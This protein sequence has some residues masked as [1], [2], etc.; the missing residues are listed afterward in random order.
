MSTRPVFPTALPGPTG[1]LPR[2]WHRV[3]WTVNAG[4][5]HIVTDNIAS[6]VL[7]L[8]ALKAHAESHPE[9]YQDV[10]LQSWSDFPPQER[11]ECQS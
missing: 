6:A 5:Q 3:T 11:P 8:V 2:G 9:E 1:P 7:A 10:Q 4:I